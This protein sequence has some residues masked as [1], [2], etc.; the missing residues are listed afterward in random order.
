MHDGKL[1]MGVVKNAQMLYC[2]LSG[3]M[4][5]VKHNATVLLVFPVVQRLDA[6]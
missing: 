4:W 5:Q 3:L 2:V 1:K 6:T